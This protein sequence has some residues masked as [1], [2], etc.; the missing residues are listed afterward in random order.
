MALSEESQQALPNGAVQVT[1]MNAETKPRDG[2]ADG[3]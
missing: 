1:M 3:G 2:A